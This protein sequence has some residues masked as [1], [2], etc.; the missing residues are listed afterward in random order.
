MLRSGRPAR[1]HSCA[2]APAASSCI[3]SRSSPWHACGLPCTQAR[4]RCVQQ[5][6]PQVCTADG[7]CMDIVNAVPYIQK[8]HKHPVTGQPLE[9]KDLIRCVCVLEGGYAGCRDVCVCM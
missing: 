4:L 9:L 1:P 7:S 8:F 2:A 5:P 6:P 3:T